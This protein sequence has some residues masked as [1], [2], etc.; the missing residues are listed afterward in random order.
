MMPTR[1]NNNSIQYLRPAAT[2]RGPPAG[3]RNV[4][5]WQDSRHAAQAGNGGR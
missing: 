4:T 5:T 2:L 1:Q 3:L